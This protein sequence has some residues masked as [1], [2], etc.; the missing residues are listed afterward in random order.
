MRLADLIQGGDKVEAGD[1]EVTGFG[2][3][4]GDVD[5][6]GFAI[7]NR[8]V[9]PGNVF[10]AFVGATVNG[11]DFIAQAVKAG[12]VAIVA[13]PEARAAIEAAGAVAL[14]DDNPRRAFA[15]LAAPFYAPLPETLVAVT[16]T[17]GKTS[18]VEMLRQI[19]RMAGHSAASIGTLGITTAD[20]TTY[21][22]LT[23]P[24][25]VTFLANLAG[26]AREGV[27][28]VAYEASSHGL[29]QYRSEGP[30]VTAGAFTNLS[31][32]HLDY[33]A[34][35]ED[36]F[37]AKMR[38]FDEVVVDGGSAVVWADDAWSA[39]AIEHVRARGLRLITVGEGGETIR[40]IRREPGPLGQVLTIVHEGAERRINLPLIGAY[41]AANALVAAGLAL[42]GGL[43]PA[44][45][46]DALGRLAPVRGRL[47]RAAIN[48]AGAPAYV[49]YAH[50]PDAL[51]AA[52]AALRPHT[53]GRL[54]VVFGAGGDRD[55]GKR[56][57]MGAIA[58]AQ[59]DI[60][61]VTDDNPR[62][63]DPAA[64]RAAV[65]AG[66]P[67][68]LIEIGDR[69]EAIFQG[70]AQAKRDDIL[71]IAGK[72]HEQGQIVGRGPDARVLPFDDVTVA[73]EAAGEKV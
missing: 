62:G 53:K 6:T 39:R 54:I 45:V 15:R 23:T 2:V 30:R 44:Q 73:R 67:D 18:T 34:T 5:V 46:F 22:G 55:A 19:W 48:A 57:P 14:V 69:R 51:E 12:A 50:T 9:A 66:A 63:E 31:R 29:S 47:E 71:L 41:Q 43:N 52:I 37:A 28:H 17:N 68:R 40:L 10:G 70:T 27:S 7:D 20:E 33:H 36:Y 38:L 60:A 25:I 64:I 65:I 32:D 3:G 56:A 16:G 24:D 8:K 61:I 4:A 21:T 11:E 59:A 49:D 13:R 72:G 58:G 42:A 1:V 26:L 35:M